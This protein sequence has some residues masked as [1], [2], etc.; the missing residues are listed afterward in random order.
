MPHSCHEAI[1]ATACNS[2]LLPIGWRFAG[3][4]V[5]RHWTHWPT[6]VWDCC[7]FSCCGSS[8][9]ARQLSHWSG[10]QWDNGMLL[11]DGLAYQSFLMPMKRIRREPTD[12]SSSLS[13]FLDWSL[14]SALAAVSCS[15]RCTV[16]KASS[17]AS[18]RM[19]CWAAINFST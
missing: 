10:G 11:C 1:S 5:Q 2:L 4:L 13:S 3:L 19:P 9:T 6:A 12:S 8:C 16:S 17:M 15:C 18:G 14:S 7:S